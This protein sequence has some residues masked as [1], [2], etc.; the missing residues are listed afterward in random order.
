[1]EKPAKPHTLRN[2]LLT[3]ALGMS[4]TFIRVVMPTHFPVITP[5]IVI[6][7]ALLELGI[8]ALILWLNWADLK[9][10]LTKKPTSTELGAIVR[11][12]IIIYSVGAVFTLLCAAVYYLIT[13][14]VYAQEVLGLVPATVVGNEF[15]QVFPLGP[16]LTMSVIAPLW[17]ELV[18]RLTFRKAFG[19]TVVFV[20][21]QALFFGVLHTANFLSLG[22]ID[23]AFLGIMLACVY[24]KT[25]DI[26]ITIGT[27]MLYNIMLFVFQFF[28]WALSS[29]GVLSA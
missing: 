1:M 17:E 18:F 10:L 27:H 29:L 21:M 9:G 6:I 13:G 2:I 24:L 22:M 5:V 26:R 16:L 12:W 7:E 15:I 14:K 8:C 19:N 28:G 11:Y 25:K 20:V 3:I 4:V 23:C